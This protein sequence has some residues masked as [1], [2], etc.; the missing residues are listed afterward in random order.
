MRVYFC[1]NL[2]TV[3]MSTRRRFSKKSGK[4]LTAAVATTGILT[5]AAAAALAYSRR[6]GNTSNNNKPTPDSKKKS[7]RASARPPD[8]KKRSQKASAT[9]LGPKR[10]SG[11]SRTRAS[12]TPPSPRRRT[13]RAS[14]EKHGELTFVCNTI[15]PQATPILLSMGD[16]LRLDYNLMNFRKSN[17]AE[18]HIGSL[19][20]SSTVVFCSKREDVNADVRVEL[21]KN[22]RIGFVLDPKK[23]IVPFAEFLA[24]NTGSKVPKEVCKNGAQLYCDEWGGTTTLTSKYSKKKGR[25]AWGMGM[26]RFS[27]NHAKWEHTDEKCGIYH[28]DGDLDIFN[29]NVWR[30]AVKNGLQNIQTLNEALV[31]QK[32]ENHNPIMGI[33][34]DMSNRCPIEQ[35]ICNE[36]I[37]RF[38]R[39]PHL[40]LMV[41]NAR[42][43]CGGIA[44]MV[45][46]N[47]NS[48]KYSETVRH[49]LNNTDPF[50]E[51]RTLPLYEYSKFNSN[52]NSDDLVHSSVLEYAK[53]LISDFK[54]NPKSQQKDKLVFSWGGDTKWPDYDDQKKS[55]THKYK[56]NHPFVDKLKCWQLFNDIVRDECMKEFKD[57]DPLFYAAYYNIV[58][59]LHLDTFLN[60]SDYRIAKIQMV[61]F[62]TLNPSSETKSYVYALATIA[63]QL[64]YKCKTF[65]FGNSRQITDGFIGRSNKGVDF[66]QNTNCYTKDGARNTW[67]NLSTTKGKMYICNEQ[68]SFILIQ[69]AQPADLIR[70]IEFVKSCNVFDL[71]NIDIDDFQ[72]SPPTD[73]IT[74]TRSH[75]FV[76]VLSLY[77]F[78]VLGESRHTKFVKEQYEHPTVFER[79]RVTLVKTDKDQMSA[80]DS[81]V[82]EYYQTRHPIHIE[83]WHNTQSNGSYG[84]IDSTKMFEVL[85]YKPEDAVRVVSKCAKSPQLRFGV[86]GWTPVNSIVDS[87][88]SDD[89]ST[90]VGHWKPE[91][92]VW[93]L[94]TWGVNCESSETADYHYCH[95][96]HTLKPQQYQHLLDIL[97]DLIKKSAV[98]LCNLDNTSAVVIRIPKLGLGVWATEITAYVDDIYKWYTERVQRLADMLGDNIYVLFADYQP[99]NGKTYLYRKDRQPQEFESHADP[100]GTFDRRPNN[101]NTN[102]PPNS[103]YLIVNAWDE[104][105]FIGN[106]CAQDNSMDGWTVAGSIFNQSF[107]YAVECLS[108]TAPNT[109]NH[110]LHHSQWPPKLGAQCENASFLHNA[111]FQATDVAVI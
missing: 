61:E 53:R 75:R 19:A 15:P 40:R 96:N 91:D 2:F 98:H 44:R 32:D 42:Q 1:S 51:A 107:P 103:K 97:F 95:N 27:C 30:K 66:V 10:K 34:V 64:K 68:G 49:F 65:K 7:E 87:F 82:R 47:L 26:S 33:V 105:S 67:L 110:Y 35:D 100:F 16:I 102:I 23:V 69:D 99:M 57:V 39:F 72:A 14:S 52:M 84:S 46:P 88:I 78:Q 8:S 94:H 45:P 111:V 83:A 41:Y 5:A 22:S 17:G 77:R 54:N 76:Q 9:S 43:E 36:L 108:S 73:V 29:K 79:M 6:H 37:L 20:C 104:G 70:T 85:E 21:Y 50:A 89:S 56:T 55:F 38:K 62:L 31:L 74:N 4:T 80:D 63:Q 13:R 106:A 92:G 93:F 58:D 90:H 59:A 25:I 48:E 24:Y 71:D 81:K 18:G 28:T 86:L 109:F 12:A 101:C 3:V 60:E 11:R